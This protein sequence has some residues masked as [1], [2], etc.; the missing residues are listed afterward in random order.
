MRNWFVA[1]IAGGIAMFIWSSIAHLMLPLGTT[2][3]SQ[4]PNE[5]VLLGAMHNTLGAKPGLYFFPWTMD[6]NGK[7]LPDA[8]TRMKAAPTGLLIYHPPGQPAEFGPR[9][10]L[11][12]FGKELVTAWIAA[13]LLAQ[14]VLAGYVAR[15][16]FVSLIG[17]AASIT[18]NV[19]YWNWYGFP[20]SYTL[21][22]GFT[23]FMGYVAA[24]FAI[25]AILPPKKRW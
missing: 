6:A 3:F 13:F 22:Y 18:T 16:G 19:S 12:E 20:T 7:M 8:E 5:T 11:T 15:V 24:A 2:G 9:T 21:A 23:D 10:L 4:I 25:A 1:G 14:A 17:L